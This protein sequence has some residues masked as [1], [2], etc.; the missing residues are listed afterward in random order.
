[1][2]PKSPLRAAM[3][4]GP[5]ATEKLGSTFKDAIFNTSDAGINIRDA[6]IN[7]RDAISKGPNRSI[8][9]RNAMKK[10]QNTVF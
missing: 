5:T 2:N 7:I 4:A 10:P 8:L 3:L 9:T 6:G 1:M